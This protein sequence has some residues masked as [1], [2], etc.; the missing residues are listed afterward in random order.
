VGRVAGKALGISNN[1][2]VEATRT[3][4]RAAVVLAFASLHNV[5][6]SLIDNR[7]A[8][9]QASDREA[10]ERRIDAR[11][12]QAASATCGGPLLSC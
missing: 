11:R 3:W 1:V 6:Y 2:R 12:L 7:R 10:V 5:L 4:W 8:A 9:P